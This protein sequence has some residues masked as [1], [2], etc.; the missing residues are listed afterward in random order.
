MHQ[1][2]APLFL[3]D[4]W[5]VAMPSSKLKKGQT[6]G[7]VLLDKPF[8]LGRR[9]DGSLFC[10]RDICPHRALPL[11]SGSFDGESLTC[12]YH[13]WEFNTEGRCTKIPA[14]GP[15]TD[16]KTE[17][18]GIPQFEVREQNG[19]IAIYIPSSDAKSND[20]GLPALSFDANQHFYH[21]SDHLLNADIDNAVLGLIDPAHVPNVHNSW[22]WRS[23]KKLKKKTKKFEPFENGFKMVAHTPASGSKVHGSFKGKLKIEISFMLPGTRIE[24]I[25][26]GRKGRISL[27]TVLSPVDHKHTLLQQYI[28]TNLLLVK[29]LLPL[30]KRFGKRFIEQDVWVLKKQQEGL[31]FN[32][33][34]MLLG[35]ADQ[36]AKW[37]LKLKSNY[38]K[39][40]QDVNVKVKHPVRPE[41]TLTWWT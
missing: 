12:C 13:G 33:K 16:F 10:L 27:L 4:C 20:F 19:L 26:Y 22:W 40:K 28:Y 25:Q 2:A 23:P 3:E 36:Q 14:L 37:Y 30:L 9:L 32:P 7:R 35:E 39:K 38:R 11:T 17:K 31:R 8:L 18:I 24:Q 29:L 21:V 1:E 41:T 15:D 6:T 5:Y 34:T